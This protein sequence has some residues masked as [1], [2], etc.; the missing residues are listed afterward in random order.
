ML[1]RDKNGN[2]PNVDTLPGWCKVVL[3]NGRYE[4]YMTMHHAINARI[5]ATAWAN[6]RE[7]KKKPDGRPLGWA[8]FARHIKYVRKDR[9][10]PKYRGLSYAVSD[11]TYGH[12]MRGTLPKDEKVRKLL[13]KLSGYPWD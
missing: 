9:P 10:V 1:K 5:I 6:L 12:F 4:Y 7:Q 11:R 8:D 3:P 2:Y 13:I